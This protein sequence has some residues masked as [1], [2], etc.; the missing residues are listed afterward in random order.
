[1]PKDIIVVVKIDAKPRASES[2]D[3]LLLSTSGKQDMETYRSLDEVAE[4]FPA[5]SVIHNKV[6]ALFEQGKTTLADTLIRKVRIVGIDKPDTPAAMIAA[7]EALRRIDDD[8]YILLT[9]TDDDLHVEALCAWAEATEPTE[10]ELGAGIEDHRKFYFGQTNNRKLAVTNARCAIIYTDKPEEHADAAY[11]GNVGPFFPRAVTWKFK[12]PQGLTI[13]NLTDAQR[14]A[15]EEAKINFLTTEYKREYVKNG[16]CMNGE[17]IDVQMGADYIA[18]T[19]RENLYD[20]FLKNATVPYTDGGFSL[21]AGAVF[22]AL[23]RA[24]T[25]GI[26]AKD[27]ESDAGVY[28]VKVPK[29]SEATDDEARARQMPDLVWEA[30]LEGAVH[31]VKVTGT[32]RATLSA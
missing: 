20:V 13:P 11:L 32:L 1:M 3:V 31:S 2:L 27:P 26:I 17:F 9:D 12:R 10:A 8:W 14:D 6:T 22:S 16:T 19:M 18:R 30:L 4:V 23:N 25:L 7:I 24:V 21:V 29:R 28:N 5:G 15:L